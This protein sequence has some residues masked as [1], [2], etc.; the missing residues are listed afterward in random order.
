M[1]IESITFVRRDS[2]Y[3]MYVPG[4]E[5]YVAEGI[6]H[7]NTGVGKNSIALGILWDNWRQGRKRLVFVSP[8]WDLIQDAMR[9]LDR[10]GAHE[11]LRG[12]TKT[13][14]GQY[15]TS[16]TS[17]V[18]PFS[19]FKY[20]DK[21]KHDGILFSTYALI[22]SESNKGGKRITQLEEYLRGD[23]DGEGAYI[24]YD[25]SHTLKSAV[26][27]GQGAKPSQIGK[28][29]KEL[30]QRMPKL[31]STSLSAT[32][33]TDV[34]N[35][36][37]LDRLGLW[38]PGTPFPTGFNEF[39]TQISGGKLAAMEMVARELKAQGKYLSRTLSFKGVTYTEEKHS[40][41]DDQKEMYRT[42]AKAWASVVQRAEASI[43]TTTNGG[44]RQ[45]ARFLSNLGSAQQRFFGILITALKTPTAIELANAALAADKSVVITLVN[46]NEAAQDREKNKAVEEGDEEVPD[47][48]FGPKR[49]LIDLVKEHFP[50]QQY[51]D[52]VDDNG[53]PVKVA[54]TTIDAD[55]REINVQ[56]PE[57]VKE[58]DEL[59]AQL[60]KDLHMPENPL[61]ILIN[62]LG[63]PSKVAELTGRKERFDGSVQ[64]FVPRG[65]PEVS[66]KD[67][68]IVEMRNF[69]SGKKRV[70]VLSGAADT[71]ISLH[72][73]LNVENQQQRYHIT[74]QVGWSAEKAMQM[75]GRTHRTNQAHPPEYVL[76]VSDLG[77]EKRFISTISR[78]LGSLGALTKG[79]K[80]AT[81]GTDL[82]DK[83]NF[84]TE[85]GAQATTAFYDSL[86][87]NGVVPG[88]NLTGMQILTDLRVLEGYP[89]TVPQKHRGNV[90]R[91]LNRLL[92]LDPDVQNPTYNYFYD[93]FQAAVE[94]AIEAGTLDT[95]VKT[96]P[97]DEFSI[98]EARAIS[99]DPKTGADTFYYPIEAR[100]KTNRVS[101]A[102][103]DKRMITHAE[104]NPRI[105]LRPETK[106]LALA[107][108][109]DP[110]VHA[111]GGVEPASYVS[112]ASQGR[113]VKTSNYKLGRATEIGEWAKDEFDDARS[114]L[115]SATRAEKYH[116]DSVARNAGK[117]DWQ[118]EA[119]D[120]AKKTTAEA[121]RVFDEKQEIAK[122]PTKW[123]K[124][125][126]ARQYEDAPGHVSENHHLI[127]G[128]VMRFW[129]PIREASAF[130]NIY[131]TVDSKTGQRVVGVDIPEETIGS[132][133]QRIT[134]GASTVNTRQLILDVLKNNLNYTLEGNLQVRRGR[135]GRESVIQIIPANQEQA[136]NL[137]SLGVV[138]E[139]GVVPM[140]YIPNN[141][142]GPRDA[143]TYTILRSVLNQ[144]PVQGDQGEPERAAHD[145]VVPIG[146]GPRGDYRN[147]I[148]WVNPE[149]MNKIVGAI[150]GPKTIGGMYIPAR[151][152]Q[153]LPDRIQ[154]APSVQKALRDAIAD[155]GSIVAV[156][157]RPGEP[158][159]AVIARARHELFHAAEQWSGNGDR[160]KQL[161]TVPADAWENP[162]DK[163]LA[164]SAAGYAKT[165]IGNLGKLGYPVNDP[166]MMFSE[167]GAHL[168]SGP[169]GWEKL[170]LSGQ[171]AK[172]LFSRY[173]Q[174][175]P[176]HVIAEIKKIT[177][178][179]KRE[180]Y[181]EQSIR[182]ERTAR[183]ERQSDLGVDRRS[184]EQL[185]ETGGGAPGGSPRRS[186]ESNIP[187]RDER[188]A[189][190]GEIGSAPILTDLISGA[191][192]LVKGSNYS[193]A[194]AIETATTRGLGQVK[195]AST[196]LHEAFLRAAS[197]QARIAVIMR[198]A[199]PQIH[200][201]LEGSHVPIE[202]LFKYYAD[203]RLQALRSFWSDLA[204]Q[205]QNIPTDDL[206][207]AVTGAIEEGSS[208]PDFVSML[209][210][211][212]GKAG[213][214]ENP[215]QV[216]AGLAEQ[217]NWDELR[218]YLSDVFTTAAANVRPIMD[219]ADFEYVH[220]LVKNDPKVRDAD[221]IYGDEIEK[222]LRENHE[223]HDGAI[224]ER[225]GP[226]NRYIPLIA[227][228]E[229]KQGLWERLGF[230]KP[231]NAH[232]IM[233]T[234]LSRSGYTV[235]LDKLRES[236]AKS[237][238]G[239]GR[240]AVIDAAR[241]A[242]L[243][244]PVPRSGNTD[245]SVFKWRGVEYPAKKVLV[246][247]PRMIV[248]GGKTIHAAPSWDYMPTWYYNEVKGVLDKPEHEEPG[249]IRKALDAI[250]TYALQGPADLT[251]HAANI[252]G[253]LVGNTPFL[254]DS[255]GGAI[256]SSNIITKKIQALALLASV[257][258]T[259]EDAVQAFREM[260]DAG[261]L[262]ARYASVTYSKKMAD[263]SGAKLVKWTL[264][265]MIYGP[266]G[267]DARARYI[268]WKVAKAVNPDASPRELNEFVNQLGNYTPALWSSLEQ[269]VKSL[270]FSPFFTAGSTMI[271][272]GVNVMFS[273]GPVISGDGKGPPW[274]PKTAAQ[275][276]IQHMLTVGA[277]GTLA[278]WF[279]LSKE[280][281]GK[282]PWQDRRSKFLS[283]PVGGGNGPADK[284]R[285]S[286]MGNW[287]WG[288][289]PEVGYLGLYT[290]NPLFRRGAA[291]LGIPGFYEAKMRGAS[292]GQALEAAQRDSMNTLL[293]PFLG[294]EP[295]A[296]WTMATGR[297][298]YL[299]SLRD[300]NGAFGPSFMPA[301]PPKTAPGF[302]TLGRR[303]LAAGM[304][305]NAFSQTLGDVAG[306][307]G[308]VK[309]DKGRSAALND[310]LNM[311]VLGT[312]LVGTATNPYAAETALREQRRNL[313]TGTR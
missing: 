305:L 87:R 97:G 210:N 65:G 163:S 189:R 114:R 156:V 74:L 118:Q 106:K 56:N 306:I 40:L 294:P 290:F 309:P 172:D 2:Y 20:G 52:D 73:G 60:D 134:G 3:D 284:Y 27:S 100:V 271:R 310:V 39:A 212:E 152:A 109:A 196:P 195:R 124:E 256:T 162:D 231:K 228:G 166:A 157:Q 222:P 208:T 227:V 92:A 300:R 72:S 129:N 147:G 77:G 249:V 263:A 267:I 217:R 122:D 55:G 46:T 94:R 251:F 287:L 85:Q 281:T 138:Y 131:T 180:L 33:A 104:K 10:M 270:P 142:T 8:K 36:G 154:N 143:Q 130:G 121:Q 34:V 246:S 261:A 237:Y 80:D 117:Y 171:E 14:T 288:S 192:H 200:K 160:M 81:S 79:Q 31:R 219:P 255:L 139:R 75:L 47:Y 260:A 132:L 170:G 44:A 53:N 123:A 48:D 299:T 58:R 13:A 226:A 76:L 198:A 107:M 42:A 239:S 61:D 110:I 30:M 238:A 137:K 151:T 9:D 250:N 83:V 207:K 230:K 244:R 64:K 280:M 259:E 54:A 291:A 59:I 168:A 197:P 173:R 298:A 25:E 203:S 247:S 140:Y 128:A 286:K 66:R 242:G 69:Q 293:H 193:T 71:G 245:T 272:N 150:G 216:T 248:K 214:P 95:G 181:A 183:Q 115:E 12:N 295:R 153:D 269:R 38:G 187:A 232:N 50:V 86:M 308:D 311:S 146:N 262:P 103:L 148:L 21:I 15:T 224:T 188:N 304:E 93:I 221:R 229:G 67:V 202:E 211:L 234:G 235:A 268:M 23:D 62:S 178:F 63:G 145:N 120:D 297:E 184:G 233:A 7:H 26:V 113:W 301:I 99:K 175:L 218:D 28:A 201:A 6:V 240:A 182:T 273:S 112:T 89:P 177:P 213:I 236:F 35:L 49:L 241:A 108:D 32:A 278:L 102:E 179:L 105:M 126:W 98:K 307:R 223:L 209:N 302:P 82:M 283:I 127:G 22:R 133:L 167:I 165:A 312:G 125:E 161:M 149:M 51:R 159:S 254:S 169:R 296:A 303:A 1:R 265:P 253:A 111:S 176:D 29:V 119:L 274:I 57:A 191:A 276:R 282:Y 158:I 205:A 96:L 277:V 257:D 78:R 155:N 258:P 243:Q 5:N 16:S 174:L 4:P 190:S 70:A 68:N 313:R 90:T 264:S 17:F 84:E 11:M 18:Q 91:L 204:D 141:D 206:E 88:T 45:V 194:G 41:S 292:T 24:V 116:A 285:H 101:P 43:R 144:Y 275:W 252:A 19:R 136:Q 215:T 135:V 266:K 164:V 186:V 199:L 279:L 37:Y 225:L 220:G 185:P 289:G